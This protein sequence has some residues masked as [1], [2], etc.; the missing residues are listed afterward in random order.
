MTVVASVSERDSAMER[1]NED[2]PRHGI[3]ARREI[4]RPGGHRGRRGGVPTD[5]ETT[6]ASTT[7]IGV[8]IVDHPASTAISRDNP[9][10]HNSPIAPP[11]KQM[12]IVSSRNCR[13][14]SV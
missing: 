5:T 4:A 11:V 13:M 12:M 3:G 7:D 9:T 6:K 8:M 1:L 14:M 10:P 2:R